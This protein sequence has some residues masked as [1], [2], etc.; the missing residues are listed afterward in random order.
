MR[1]DPSTRT[2]MSL[3]AVE[4]V[5]SV[6]VSCRVQEMW[7]S[8]CLDNGRPVWRLWSQYFDGGAVLVVNWWWSVMMTD[9]VC[10]CAFIVHWTTMTYRR[11]TFVASQSVIS[12]I[13]S[14][15]SLRSA[16]KSLRCVFMWYLWHS[17][18]ADYFERY[19]NNWLGIKC[20]HYSCI[21]G[22]MHIGLFVV[23]IVLF[24][25]Y[26]VWMW[27]AVLIRIENRFVLFTWLLTL[28]H[29]LWPAELCAT[30]SDFG[31]SHF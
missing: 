27:G 14:P 21:I 30:H 28:V 6:N 31:K 23:H 2:E 22:R 26:Q 17:H 12:G 16:E 19:C 10:V 5:Q 4:I 9:D 20:L 8:Q 29:F 3:V 24:R 11:S 15:T 25:A 1:R 7:I 18:V 13:C